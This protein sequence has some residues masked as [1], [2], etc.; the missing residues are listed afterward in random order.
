[1]TPLPPAQRYFRLVSSTFAST[2]WLA[3]HHLH[4]TSSPG[5]LARSA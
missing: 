3:A 5:F 1:M 2:G 4:L